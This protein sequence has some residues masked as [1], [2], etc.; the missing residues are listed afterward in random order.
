MIVLDWSKPG[1]MVKELVHWLRWVDQWAET[2][3]KQG[4]ADELR[5][6]REC[7]LMSRG[8]WLMWQ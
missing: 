4:E 2:A 3:A 1:S 6:R 7:T 8:T 5:D